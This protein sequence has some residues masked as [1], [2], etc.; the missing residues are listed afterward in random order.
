MAVSTRMQL[1]EILLIAVP[2]V[3][4]V[5]GAFALAYQFVEPAPP[6]Q[7]TIATSGPKSAYTL[8]AEEYRQG[9]AKAGITLDI[10]HTAG[11]MENIDLLQDPKANVQAAIVQGGIAKSEKNPGLVS[12][13]RLFVEPL[14][15]FHKADLKIDRLAD[16]KGLKVSAGAEGSGTRV[17]AL[18][19][20]AS[21]KVDTAVSMAPVAGMKA[22]DQLVAG[23]ID[24]AIFTLSATSEIAQKLLRSPS[25]K[26][27]DMRQA[28]AYT[29]LHPYLS[30]I[31]L[32]A[33]VIDLAAN[34]P[35][36]DTTLVAPVATL[37]A[38]ADIHPA[39]VTLLVEATKAVHHEPGLFQRANEFPQA[40]E[41]ELPL[42]ADAARVH[43]NGP[44]FLQRYLPFWLATFLDRML[45]MIIPIAT[46]L[47]PLARLAP[48]VY[49][50]SIRRRI[51]FW[52][53][54][55]KQL[56]AQV[57]ADTARARLAEHVEEMERIE[58]AVAIIPVPMMYSDQ[59]Y[60]L[61]SA[62]ELVRQRVS[63]MQAKETAA[64]TGRQTA[65]A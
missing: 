24:V 53:D 48:M 26:L 42:H 44:P 17:L 13:G 54:R 16:L 22:A 29:R 1:R 37:V 64:A 35:A 56:E 12:L 36:Q 32:P 8:Y 59:L 65:A 61:R 52:Y 4:V 30:R 34:I 60:T 9:L 50:W 45:V 63:A 18:S 51:M 62:V 3:A 2:T 23:E 33:G 41:A 20:L 7:L 49:Q 5:I 57:R 55:L 31:V 38:R 40:V 46:I 25:V 14:W 11:S 58:D 27:L 10:R 15:V 19:L 43:K 21:S 47:L 39:L 6:R 28:E